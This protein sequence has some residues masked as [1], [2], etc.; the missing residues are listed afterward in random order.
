MLIAGNWKMHTDLAAA[1]VLARNIAAAV[2]ERGAALDGVDLAVCPPSVNLQAVRD[3]LDDTAVRVGAQNMHFADEGAYTGEV[4][5]PM[6]HAVGCRYVILGHSERRQ[7]FGEDDAIVNKKVQQAVAHKL[8]PIVCVGETKAQRDAGDAEDVVR[9]QVR[10]ALQGVEIEG[11]EQLVVAYEP[12]WAIGTGDTA[13]PEQAEA[14]H[15]Y[16]ENVLADLYDEPIASGV[17]I[18]YGGSMKPHNAESLL[19]Q[20]HIDGGLV[21]GASLRAKDFLGIADAAV[22]VRAVS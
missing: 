2:D 20:P 9:A 3:A 21:G 11:A 10:G 7:Y 5:A 19:A 15:A 18:L 14:M 4:S 6:L 1:Q 13:T 22:A 16:I 17:E 8:I 12:V